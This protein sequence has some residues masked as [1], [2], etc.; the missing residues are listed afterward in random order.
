MFEIFGILNGTTNYILT[1][2]YEEGCGYEE[3]LAEAQRLGYAERDP[4]ADV[5]G[6]DAARKIAILSSL[7]YGK[8]VNFEDLPVIGI[9]NISSADMAYAKFLGRKIKLLGITYKSGDEIFSEVA[10]H[11]IDKTSVLYNV[12]GV[13]NGIAVKGNLLGDTM[14]YGAGAGKLPTASA[15]VS[16]IIDEAK[17]LNKHI[18]INWD[19]ESVKF[20]ERG[21]HKSRFFVRADKNCA[22]LKNLF[23]IEQLI[24]LPEYPDEYAVVTEEMT[25]DDFYGKI[26][27]NEHVKSVIQLR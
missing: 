16:D 25:F 3:T 23:E 24:T 4:S 6:W 7:I 18:P 26:D 19:A 11:M 22:D 2:M 27:G 21:K 5:D 12:D 9:R 10:P 20:A 1:K 15:V 13:M 14:F 8:N 17:H